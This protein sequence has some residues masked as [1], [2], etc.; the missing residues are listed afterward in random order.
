[1]NK[2]NHYIIAGILLLTTS[3]GLY[4]LHFQVF[5]DIHHIAIFLVSDLAFLPIEI[6]LVSI[7]IDRLLRERDRK[8][9]LQKLNMVIGVFFSEIG[10]ELLKYLSD[11]DPFLGEIKKDL[12]I[13]ATWTEKNFKELEQKLKNR[14]Y[15]IKIAEMN[16]NKMRDFLEKKRDFLIKILENPVLLAHETF[17]ELL[18]A[19][20]HLQEELCARKN[21]DN[22]HPA[23]IT[24]LEIDNERVYGHL[25]FEWVEY[26]KYLKK[27]YPFL[28]SFAMRTNPFDEKANI[29]VK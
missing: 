21:L 3:F 22:L 20:F 5:H 15:K 4:Y 18:K 16:L 12:I 9:I 1:M 10:T 6:L 26:M 29:E 14:Q 25:V 11:L 13:N 23:D 2:I 19:V 8:A 7:I 24:H 27:D 28:F 17:T